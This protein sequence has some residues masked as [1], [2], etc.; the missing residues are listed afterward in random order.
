VGEF[1][2]CRLATGCLAHG[3][4]D[5]VHVLAILHPKKIEPGIHRFFFEPGILLPKYGKKVENNV[6]ENQEKSQFSE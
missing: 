3:K 2:Y 6:L 1:H 4:Q 5:S